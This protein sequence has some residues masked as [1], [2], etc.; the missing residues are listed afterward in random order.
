MK[1][2]TILSAVAITVLSFSVAHAQQ[3]YV[4]GSF[5]GWSPGSGTFAGGG[6]V[7]AT[8]IDSVE[9]VLNELLVPAAIHD[10]T[11]GDQ[12]EFKITFNNWDNA[13]PNDN[14]WFYA[15]ATGTD[16]TFYWDRRTLDDGFLPDGSIIYTS[17]ARS[18][19]ESTTTVAIVGD[20]YPGGDNW[21]PTS[22]NNTLL[23]D[24]GSGETEDGLWGATITGLALGSY[25]FKIAV[26]ADPDDENGWARQIT[27]IGMTTNGPNFSFSVSGPDDVVTVLLD[28]DTARVSVDVE[29]DEIPEDPNYYAFLWTNDATSNDTR[30]DRTPLPGLDAFG[31]DT[32]LIDNG[33]YFARAFTIADPGDYLVR[34]RQFDGTNYPDSGPYPFST[35]SA[36]QE[37]VVIFD[38]N[39]YTDGYLPA[40]D[41]V[42]VLGEEPAGQRSFLNQWSRVQLV[43]PQSAF[44]IGDDFDNPE[45]GFNKTETVVGSQIYAFTDT[46]SFPGENKQ[47]K[48]VLSRVG[49]YENSEDYWVIQA[50]GEIDG[51]TF[52][53]NNNAELN[54]YDFASGTAYTIKT[55][56]V[57]G[58][59]GTNA[60]LS[61]DKNVADPDRGAEYFTAQSG[62][63]TETSASDW[64][65][66]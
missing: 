45:A 2:S 7:E 40:T 33:S 66:F 34:V 52:T 62:N 35:T 19:L 49:G 59:V 64:L 41:F 28:L 1:K 21:N 20:V 31:P 54:P 58:R 38:R 36:N 25:E 57:T 18:S 26:D 63:T 32:V 16:I 60:V 27:P 24:A 53:G 46:A 50:G 17:A 22:P 44:R 48:S 30:G 15:P 9:G 29:G 23:T 65:M 56:A 13:V 8:E 5:N 3:R 43:G 10:L 37:V 47:V 14:V 42:V 11:P 51:L 6:G 55:D 12:H 4:T 39:E 61:G